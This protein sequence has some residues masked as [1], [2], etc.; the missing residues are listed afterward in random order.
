MLSRLIITLFSALLAL[1]AVASTGVLAADLSRGFSDK[2]NWVDGLAK[3]SHVAKHRVLSLEACLYECTEW[4][5][6]LE[7]WTS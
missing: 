3:V 5:G 6:V 7:P 1:V 4:A 2:I